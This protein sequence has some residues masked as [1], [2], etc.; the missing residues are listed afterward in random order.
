MHPEAQ[1]KTA[2]IIHQGLYEFRVMPFGLPAVLMQRVVSP[3]NADT[4]PDFVSVY[5]DDILFSP[6]LEQHLQSSV[7][8]KQARGSQHCE[9]GWPE[10][11]SNAAVQELPALHG[12]RF[13]GLASYYRRFI[14][15]LPAHFTN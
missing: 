15:G 1:E 3:L 11:K 7:I 4:G 9:P 5:L 10:D 8:F 6:T 14:A 13:L 12:V 2:F